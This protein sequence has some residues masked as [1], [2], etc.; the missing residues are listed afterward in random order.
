MI[1]LNLLY[2]KH[3]KYVEHL[4]ATQEILKYIETYYNT[5]RMH[6]ALDYKSPK[7]FEKYDY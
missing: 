3:K 7:D 6:S 5:K 1:F 4:E 2:Q